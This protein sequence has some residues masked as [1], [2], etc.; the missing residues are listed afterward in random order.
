MRR[1]FSTVVLA[2][3]V[4]TFLLGQEIESVEWKDNS[5]FSIGL[6][7]GLSNADTDT[8][9]IFRDGGMTFAHA[10]LMYGLNAQYNISDNLGIRA[11][12]FETNISGD[13]NDFDGPCND[14]DPDT[15]DPCEHNARGWSFESPLREFSLDLAWEPWGHKRYQTPAFFD[16]NGNKISNSRISVSDATYYDKDGNE[17][18]I[19]S[20]GKFKKM[21]SP[22]LLFGVSVAQTDPELNFTE[23]PGFATA[24]RQEADLAQRQDFYGHMQWGVG[25]RFD[26]SEK[27][28]LDLEAR[29]VVP[30]T[31]MIDGMREVAHSF[32]G[33]NLDNNDDSYQFAFARLG[34]RLG[35]VGDCDS[36]GLNDNFD[37]CKCE[38]GEVKNWGCPDTDGDGIIDKNDEC[39]GVPG[40]K[41]HNGCPD[42]DGDGVPDKNDTC[43]EV[44]GMKKFNGCADTDGD[45]IPDNMDDCPTVAGEKEFNGCL[46]PDTD[47]DGVYDRDDECPKTPGDIN[48]CPDTDGDGIVDKND[49]C[50]DTPGI[51]SEMGCPKKVVVNTNP[52]LLTCETIYFNTNQSSI[53]NK[54]RDRYLDAKENVAIM[55]RALA[56]LNENPSYRAVVQGH[57][58][59]RNTDEYNQKLSERRANQVL[60]EMLKRGF[61]AARTS[62]IGFGE[63]NP[64]S[65]NDTKEGRAQNRRVE[66]C[67]YDK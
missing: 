33:E 43:P 61:P 65:T 11:N 26:L 4:S 45:N 55:E 23:T 9:S 35:G 22:Y 8:H 52:V 16:A 49:K 37:R 19:A 62:S 10:H 47:G 6:N 39:P 44:A 32:D 24:A 50:P 7:V 58:D 46:P 21:I 30:T 31:D 56:K 15:P 2:V 67:I 13:D 36:D 28:F 40:R 20:F 51:A 25:L 18:N 42:T 3:F 59:S 5:K 41:I 64:V 57:T 53:D 14:G 1:C 48:G 17:L 60:D 12:W 54:T 66:I 29:G 38:P 27:L 34:M 63:T